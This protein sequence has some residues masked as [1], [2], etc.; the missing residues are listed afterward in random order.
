MKTKYHK[1]NE[2][3]K[4]M[5]DVYNDIYAISIDNKDSINTLLK[6]FYAVMDKWGI[7]Q[8]TWSENGRTMSNPEWC[9]CWNTYVNLI[10]NKIVIIGLIGNPPENLLA[11][12]KPKTSKTS[13]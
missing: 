3:I 9:M 4:H 7:C 8:G 10:K 13:K 12:G 6:K 1:P 11:Y 5:G 2:Y